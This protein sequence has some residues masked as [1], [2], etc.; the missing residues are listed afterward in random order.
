MSVE[1]LDEVVIE[2]NNDCCICL[3]SDSQEKIKLDCCRNDIH[4]SCFNH[5]I[6]YKMGDRQ[7]DD[8]DTEI[9]FLVNCPLCRKN[10]IHKIVSSELNFFKP[11]T[12]IRRTTIANLLISLLIVI[13][14]GPFSYWLINSIIAGVR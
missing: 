1:Q 11:P 2:I 4:K 5:L 10:F 12:R 14:F 9:S 3:E 8:R 13:V 7:I 6:K